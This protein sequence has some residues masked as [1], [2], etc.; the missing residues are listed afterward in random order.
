M[1]VWKAAPLSFGLYHDYIHQDISESS[2]PYS[3]KGILR[4]L[5][6]SHT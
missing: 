5:A 2:G 6:I 1:D 3:L 4:V